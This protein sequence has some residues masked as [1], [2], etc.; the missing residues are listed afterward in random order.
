M[1]TILKS[2]KQIN[3]ALPVERRAW[4]GLASRCYVTVTGDPLTSQLRV[5]LQQGSGDRGQCLV[6]RI[7][8]RRLIGPF[9]LDADGEVIAGFTA[10]ETGLARM[11]GPAVERHKLG[12]PAVTLN[13]QM[14][15]DFQPL[16]LF[17]ERVP[18]RIQTI[19]KQFGNMTTA[20]LP[21]RQADIVNHQ[22]RNLA[23][24]TLVAVG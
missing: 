24:W 12:H 21:G 1:K 10:L 22:Q 6:L 8:I 9:Q 23:L 20:E 13:Q 11:P 4:V 14:R 7:G 16:D 3:K 15:G 18:V 2:P 17:K 19:G 5:G